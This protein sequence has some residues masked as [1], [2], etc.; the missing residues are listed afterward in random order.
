MNINIITRIFLHTSLNFNASSFL[1]LYEDRQACLLLDKSQSYW[2]RNPD[3]K[4]H[5]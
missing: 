2:Q 4:V 1:S 5:I 3:A